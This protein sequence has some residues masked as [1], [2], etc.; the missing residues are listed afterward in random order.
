MEW[1]LRKVTVIVAEDLYGLHVAYILYE[2]SALK[3]KKW[4]IVTQEIEVIIVEKME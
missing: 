4:K 2:S 1:C 3:I